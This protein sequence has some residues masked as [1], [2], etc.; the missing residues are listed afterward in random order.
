MLLL[1]PSWRH[2]RSSERS[3]RVL[4][5]VGRPKFWTTDSIVFSG[6]SEGEGSLRAHAE[7]ESSLR[8]AVVVTESPALLQGPVQSDA[9]PV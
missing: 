8:A 4:L 6:S 3:H 2:F 1:I 5:A 7:S 9:I